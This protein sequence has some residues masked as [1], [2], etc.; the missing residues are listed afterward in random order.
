MCYFIYVGFVTLSVVIFA[1]GGNTTRNLA[2]A[3]SSDFTPHKQKR[4]K[5]IY[6]PVMVHLLE[7]LSVLRVARKMYYGW[8]IRG[9]IRHGQ[10]DSYAKY[11]Y[12]ID[13]NYNA[14]RKINAA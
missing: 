6:Y 12:T 2:R 8:L 3:E 10:Y 13:R 14:R 1:E 4:I 5:D 9:Y 11:S 7:F